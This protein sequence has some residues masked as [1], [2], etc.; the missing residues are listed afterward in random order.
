MTGSGSERLQ[1]WI[2]PGLLLVLRRGLSEP[3][4]AG[5]HAPHGVSSVQEVGDGAVRQ[6]LG[7]AGPRG[8]LQ[9]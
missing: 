2:S 1:N 4:D 6:S 7:P 8:V 3:L 9:P 5:L